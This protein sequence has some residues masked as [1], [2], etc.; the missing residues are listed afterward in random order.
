MCMTMG[1]LLINLLVGFPGISLDCAAQIFK[2]WL[3]EKD[4]RE[5]FSALK[6]VQ[7]DTRLQVW[8][9]CSLPVCVCAC[10]RMCACTCSESCTQ[11]S[12]LGHGQGRRQLD[13]VKELDFNVLQAPALKLAQ[14]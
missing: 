3:Q 11:L 8:V 2:I 7:I 14:Q 6:K 9:S 1:P 10:V 12:C 4:V 5:V 13:V